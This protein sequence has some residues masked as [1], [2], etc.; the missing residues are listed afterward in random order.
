[1]RQSTHALAKNFL[2]AQELIDAY[3][4]AKREDRETL[5]SLKRLRDAAANNA[6]IAEYMKGVE[7][8]GDELKG[9]TLPSETYPDASK[10]I[11]LLP[12]DQ[13]EAAEELLNHGETIEKL[14]GRDGRGGVIGLLGEF[15]ARVAELREKLAEVHTSLGSSN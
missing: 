5:P 10:L 7:W 8:E 9:T 6:Y 15:K 11:L 4:A 12:E 1:L 2:S 3:L 13:R 14:R